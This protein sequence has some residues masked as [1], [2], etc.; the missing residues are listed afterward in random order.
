MRLEII[1]KPSLEKALSCI[2]KALNSRDYLVVF[3]ECYVEYEGRGSS[4]LTSGERMLI[5][6]QDGA[7]LLH[8]PEGYSPVNWQPSTSSIE[9]RLLHDGK[10]LITAIRSRPREILRIYFTNIEAVIKGRLNDN[11][12]FVMYLSEAEIRDIIYDNP[13]ILEKGL[14]IVEKEKP[15]DIGYIDLFGYDINGNP[16]I[17][18]L[19]RVPASKEAVRQLYNYIVQYKKKYGIRPR[20]ILV[21]PTF[22]KSAIDVAEKM[23]IEWKEINIQK[24]WR[25]KKKS[26]E[27]EMSTLDR[28]LKRR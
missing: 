10:L 20:G 19:K 21:A 23:G 15:I 12:E 3:G 11:G 22:Y 7:V 26:R 5:V 24:L 2:K 1:E 25:T 14:R 4:R 9:V 28:F 6:K 27:K 13:E 16:V 17:I 18:E 8:R